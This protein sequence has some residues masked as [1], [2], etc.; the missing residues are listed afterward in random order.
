MKLKLVLFLI[1][2]TSLL[3]GNAYSQRAQHSHQ[4]QIKNSGKT[5]SQLSQ[6]EHWRALLHIN[7]HS[8]ESALE[9]YVDDV[10]F[11][12]A[13]DGATHPENELRATISAL[14]NNADSQ[15]K[16]P[17][18][19]AFLFD[20][21]SGLRE[22]VKPVICQEY[23]DWRNKL[24]TANVV[25][26]FASAQLNSPSSMY[27]HTFLRFDPASVKQDST[28]LSYALNFGATVSEQDS[29]FLYAARGLTGG[30]PGYF[31]ANPYFEK[32]K[33]YNRLEN[34]DL[35][36][37]KLNLTTDEIN[38]MLAH[39]WELQGISFEY[40]FFDENCSFRLLELLDVARPNLYLANHFPVTAMPLDTVRVVE[41]AG[42]IAQ[43]HYRPSILT[44]LKAQLAILTEEENKLT[45][46]LSEDI[47]VLQHKGFTQLA[48]TQQQLVVDSAYRY[49]R[50]QNTFNGRPKEVTRRSFQLL[51]KLNENPATFTIPIEQPKRPDQGHKTDMFGVSVGQN[52]DRSFVEFKYRGSFHDLLDPMPGYYQGMSLN[53]VNVMLRAYE[54]GKIEIE[55]IELLDIVSLSARNH[56][57]SPW[58]WQANISIEQQWTVDKE[59]LVTQG[60]GG[61]GVSYQPLDNSYVFLLATGRLEFNGKLDSYASVA[62]G[63]HTGFLYY[64]PKTTLLIDAEHYQFLFDQTQRSRLSLQQSL[65]LGDNDSLRFSV[66]FHHVKSKEH[67]N[68]AFQEFTVEYRHY[69]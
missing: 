68:K 27:G 64:W 38:T 30:Y 67:A 18:R 25:L 28:Y 56:Y 19:T 11:F 22:D 65:Q 46:A 61:G 20:H 45:L 37:Y 55:N 54:G 44:E 14:K 16:F 62:P 2:L 47:A 60:S 49:L 15:C 9:S 40:Y 3:S 50:Y 39:I 63:L 53:M 31:A 42:L 41:N 33:E 52:L 58:S 36:E 32:I 66:D 26:V 23:I 4:Q 21:I 24:N 10:N 57:F 13:S 1:T 34:R 35:W 51:K 8:K 59:V 7:S 12:L 29:G 5:L 6:T 48:Q 43:T 69:F 17:A